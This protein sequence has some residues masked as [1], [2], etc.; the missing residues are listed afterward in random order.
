MNNLLQKII[1]EPFDKFLDKLLQ[2]LPN[3]LSSVLILI[4]GIILGLILKA[5]FQRVFHAIKL[6]KFSERSGVVEMLQ[7]GGVKE[8]LSFILSKLISWIII[9]SFL[10][11]SLQ[12][13][14]IPT[15]ERVLE[16][17]ILYLPNVFIA[18]VILLFGY[19]LG[20][21]LGRAALIAAVNAGWKVSGLIGRLVKLTVFLLSV[22]MALEQLGIGRGTIVIAFAIIF[23]GVVLALA[24]AFGLGGRD[25]AKEYLQKKIKGEEKKDEISHL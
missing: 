10:F 1:I 25:I 12:S 6:D 4:S 8:P 20:N 22:T 19:L 16:R 3:I 9:I 2:F 23:G 13:L 5:L 24:I 17:F 21:F 18:T 11:L 15:I 7:K 14:N